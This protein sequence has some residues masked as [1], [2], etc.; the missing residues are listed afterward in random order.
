M[1]SG[2][3]NRWVGAAGLGL[4][5][6]LAIGPASCGRE[7][8]A[9][10][11]TLEVFVSIAP[12]AQFAERIG[13]QGVAVHVLVPPGA[14]PAVYSPDQAKLARLQEADLL[15]R[16]GVPFEGPL[17]AKLGREYEDLEVVDLRRGVTLRP[18]EAGAHDHGEHADASDDREQAP[19]EARDAHDGHDHGEHDAHDHG[20]HDGHDHGEHDAHDHAHDHGEL[21][22]HIWLDPKRAVTI[23][24]T[25]CQ[26]MVRAD[27][28]R[29]ERYRENL[30]A[31]QA[32]LRALDERIAQTLAPL[33]G[34][35][36]YVFHP[37]YGYFAESYGLRQVAVERHG[38][39]PAAR[40]VTELIEQARAE[41][42]KVIFVQPQFS[43]RSAKVIAGEI[44]GAVVPM[45]PLA[46]DYLGNLQRMAETV[47]RR[48]G[49]VPPGG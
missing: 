44:G 42:A 41:N 23:A 28:P 7:G 35:T 12:L 45:D 33:R 31:L 40:E 9:G 29:A 19:G 24:E 2:Q 38:K 34:R 14:S 16:I 1:S 21:D 47:A 5:A 18:M 32:D 49:E 20:A 13:G 25:M 43:Q 17:L 26:A 27:P 22:P 36:L 6:L 3:A 46:R 10:E 30:A 48:L 15:F 39:E 11:A 8:A 4:A 37:A